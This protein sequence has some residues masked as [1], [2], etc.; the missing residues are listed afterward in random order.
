MVKTRHGAAY[1]VTEKQLGR[2]GVKRGAFEGRKERFSKKSDT[3]RSKWG[4]EESPSDDEESQDNSEDEAMLATKP[5]GRSLRSKAI[6]CLN[7]GPHRESQYPNHFFCMGCAN[8]ESG[9]GGAKTEQ[10]VHMRKSAKHS[11]G[12]N[13]CTGGHTSAIFPTTMKKE[14]LPSVLPNRRGSARYTSTGRKLGTKSRPIVVYNNENSSSDESSKTPSTVNSSDDNSD[15]SDDNSDSSEDNSDFCSRDNPD[16]SDNEANPSPTTATSKIDGVEQFILNSHRETMNL[17]EKVEELERTI[18]TLCRKLSKSSSPSEGDL[19]TKI[20]HG[21]EKA[22]KKA[23]R[24]RL[25]TRVAKAIASAA[26]S[27]FEGLAEIEL[28]DVTRKWYVSSPRLG[29]LAG[30]EKDG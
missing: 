15:S 25:G 30:G 1:V 17:C 28:R 11:L 2:N 8:W 7:F 6:S 16:P 21:I 22:V 29:I 19:I 23:N 26:F 10:A 12:N 13:R 20:R 27:A 24:G 14:Y 4:R 3:R 18:R 5:M 9:G